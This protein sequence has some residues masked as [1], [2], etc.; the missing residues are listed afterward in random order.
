MTGVRT[1]GR[2]SVRHGGLEDE[3][4]EGARRKGRRAKGGGVSAGKEKGGKSKRRRG[5]P[6]KNP[7]LYEALR[8]PQM[9][10]HNNSDNNN[11]NKKKRPGH[12]RHLHSSDDLIFNKNSDKLTN[13][14]E[15]PSAQT[16]A[17]PQ[18]RQNPGLDLALNAAFNLQSELRWVQAG[19]AKTGKTLVEAQAVLMGPLRVY[20]TLDFH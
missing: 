19:G 17:G 4:D 2:L 6:N 10:Y 16:T 12:D 15:T 7:P 3:E 14:P 1:A 13:L 20:L 18:G 5:D 11:N 8:M 9:M